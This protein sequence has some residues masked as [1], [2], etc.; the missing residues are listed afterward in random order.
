MNIKSKAEPDAGLISCVS[1]FFNAAPYLAQAIESVIGQSFA[2]W[3]LLLVDDGSTDDSRAIAQS[4]AARD[5]ERIRVLE[6]AGGRNEGK[7]ASRNL[8]VRSSRGAVVALLD[9]DDVWLPTKLEAQMRMFREIPAIDLVFGP[10][11]YWYSWTGRPQDR[12]R[13]CPSKISLP[14]E[15]VIEPP[16]ALTRM[17][18]V[19]ARRDESICPYPSA[20]AFRRTAFDRVG[21]FEADFPQLYDDA[22]FFAKVMATARGFIIDEVLCKYRLHPDQKQSHSYEQARIGGRSIV[23]EER[24]F[25]ARTR[26]FL[27]ARGIQEWR[28]QLALAEADLTAANVWPA[29]ALGALRLLKRTIW[30]LFDGRSGDKA[31][32]TD[33]SNAHFEGCIA[34]FA[35]DLT[36]AVGELGD[37]V[38]AHRYCKGVSAIS[39]LPALLDGEIARSNFTC[40]L[41]NDTLRFCEAPEAT[42]QRFG[43]LLVP[44][45]ILLIGVTIA[46]PELLD[47]RDRWRFSKTDARALVTRSGSFE[48]SH[49]IDWHRP[50]ASGDVAAVFL[51]CIKRDVGGPT[52]SA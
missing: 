42:M 34:R 22:V 49:E 8:G 32:H 25:L 17:L 50:D 39:V 52:R 24:R 36:G 46:A 30:R 2:E 20:T 45:G 4:Y 13:D 14:A 1:T 26:T 28:L 47:P 41:A 10:V 7:S 9:A 16:G 5:P 38:L 18:Q 12:M 23:Q 21:G 19:H 3:E 11:L 29:K 35:S 40:I 27:D 51:R 31:P 48:V 15:A 44:G 43:E 37:D 33:S 6:H